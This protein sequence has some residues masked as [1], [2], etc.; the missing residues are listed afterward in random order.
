MSENTGGANSVW[1]NREGWKSE[2]AIKADYEVAS[3]TEILAILEVT[4][5]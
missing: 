2:T 5:V 3:L 4:R 1:P